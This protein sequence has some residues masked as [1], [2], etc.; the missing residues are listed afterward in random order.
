[1]P[2]QLVLEGFNNSLSPQPL[3]LLLS[4]L[5]LLLLSCLLQ[6]RVYAPGGVPD[7]S[8][9]AVRAFNEMLLADSSVEVVLLPFRDGVSLVR[10]RWVLG[11]PAY[12]GY[13][14]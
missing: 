8:A 6:G 9:D 1:M 7:E 14:A 5:L 10:R 2:A 11:C 3:L 4:C 12:L 13:G